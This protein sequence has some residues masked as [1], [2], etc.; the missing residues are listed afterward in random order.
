MIINEKNLQCLSPVKCY[1]PP[2]LPS[3]KNSDPQQLKILPSRWKK[4]A[5]VV[6][7]L[8]FACALTLSG[9]IGES[10]YYSNVYDLSYFNHHHGGAPSAPFYVTNPTEHEV[11]QLITQLETANLELGLTWGGEASGP[12]Y[13]VYITEGEALNFIRAKLEAHGLNFSTTPP[14]NTSLIERHQQ[15]EFDLYDKD[16]GVAIT[17]LDWSHSSFGPPF[18][19]DWF[20]RNFEEGF[21]DETNDITVKA[22]YA[23]LQSVYNGLPSWHDDYD[24]DYIPEITPDMKEAARPILI[25]NLTAQVNEFINWL[26]NEGILE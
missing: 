11:A 3:L 13:V 16:K 10:R 12:I 1:K 24:P 4:N 14:P 22:F 20:A 25:E 5:A 6:T 2:M 18:S 8:G 17:K 21:D 15:I 26:K 23:P 7:C 19:G 9:C